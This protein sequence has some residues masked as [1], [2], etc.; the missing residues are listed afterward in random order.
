MGADEQS[1]RSFDFY[2][3]WGTVE[4][5]Y[6]HS[7][8]WKSQ[9]LGYTSVLFG[10]HYLKKKKS[11]WTLF[12]CFMGLSCHSLHLQDSSSL[13]G[14]LK[15]SLL[16]KTQPCLTSP[17]HDITNQKKHTRFCCKLIPCCLNSFMHLRNNNDYS[18]SNKH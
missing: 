18:L 10:L 4:P 3:S 16:P 2:F 15:C 6:S 9:G 7:K 5:K 1:G 11:H 8:Q 12:Q 14:P 13:N 17:F